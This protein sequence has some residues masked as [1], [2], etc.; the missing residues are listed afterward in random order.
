MIPEFASEESSDALRKKAEEFDRKIDMSN[1]INE[2]YQESE[3]YGEG[4]FL[5][6]EIRE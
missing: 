4:R 5:R 3:D 2:H 6:N 1:S